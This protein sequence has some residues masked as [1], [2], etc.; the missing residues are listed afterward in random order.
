MFSD[1]TEQ[2]PQ[3]LKEEEGTKRQR[4]LEAK[5]LLILRKGIEKLFI[6]NNTL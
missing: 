4:E 5:E 2:T 6:E 1:V 3:S